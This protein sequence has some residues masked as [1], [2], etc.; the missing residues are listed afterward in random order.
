ME[1]LALALAIVLAKIAKEFSDQQGW[2]NGEIAAK[3]FVSPGFAGCLAVVAAVIGFTAV[4]R[5]LQHNRHE[6]AHEQQVEANKTWWATFQW[7]ADKALTAQ[8]E[9]DTMPP[10]VAAA[11][12]LDLSRDELKTASSS[13]ELPAL[14]KSRQRACNGIALALSSKVDPSTSLGQEVLDSLTDLA[15]LTEDS[16][17]E[18]PALKRQLDVLTTRRG[19]FQKLSVVGKENGME[20]ITD[21][22]EIGQRLGIDSLELRLEADALV[23]KKDKSVWV[24][25]LPASSKYNRY[26]QVRQA[27]EVGV[28]QVSEHTN[29][30]YLIVIREALTDQFRARLNIPTHVHVVTDSDTKSADMK[31]KLLELFR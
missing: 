5:Q 30:P 22:I 19:M 23:V 15:G 24:K 9:G 12:L 2:S 13:T 16:S 7:V 6:L 14:W 28:P 8:K 27:L 26:R 29:Y 21:P 11:M 10:T 25:L 31:D 17:V 3:F 4:N 18:S 20:V 1:I